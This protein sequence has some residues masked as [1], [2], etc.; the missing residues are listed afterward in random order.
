MVRQFLAALFFCSILSVSAFSQES[1]VIVCEAGMDKVPAWTSYEVTR[2]LIEYLQCGQSVRLVDLQASYWRVQL[3]KLPI[4][5]VRNG[6]RIPAQ[7]P[8][9]RWF[10]GG[11]RFILAW[12]AIL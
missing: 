8:L 11:I 1:G 9:G 4:Q 3:G 2:G 7:K 10:N 5:P 12:M 6:N